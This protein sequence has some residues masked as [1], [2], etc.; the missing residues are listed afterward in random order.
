MLSKVWGGGGGDNGWVLL[1]WES[2]LYKNKKARVFK[3]RSA[4]LF[5]QISGKRRWAKKRKIK[6][7]TFASAEE[8]RGES[9][10]GQKL[11]FFSSLIHEAR[12]EFLVRQIPA[13]GFIRA[14]I[15][16]NQEKKLF[17]SP[18]H[19][20]KRYA[21]YF[22]RFFAPPLPWLK[23]DFF[24]ELYDRNKKKPPTPISSQTK[25]EKKARASSASEREMKKSPGAKRERETPEMKWTLGISLP[26]SKCGS[27]DRR[28]VS[29]AHLQYMNWR[30]SYPGGENEFSWP[31]L[32]ESALGVGEERKPR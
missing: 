24:F 11:F 26:P 22:F 3:I 19:T 8:F 20:K 1:R 2:S 29:R 10:R 16:T 14:E 12:Q 27:R 9:L 4:N 7:R 21:W 18:S 31:T 23:L 28:T 30:Q 13:I 17:S 15:S 5:S 32:G 6:E 25:K